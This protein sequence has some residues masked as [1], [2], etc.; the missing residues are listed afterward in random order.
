[1]GVE[2]DSKI[3]RMNKTSGAEKANATPTTKKDQER[4]RRIADEFLL[5]RLGLSDDFYW[6][7]E[8]ACM[9]IPKN[10]IIEERGFGE[11]MASLVQ[12][13]CK[14][15][16]LY[17]CVHYFLQAKSFELPD[18]GELE[19]VISTHDKAVGMI[20]RY[21]NEIITM[22]GARSIPPPPWV[23]E[24]V[25]STQDTTGFGEAIDSMPP[26]HK[27]V[28]FLRQLLRWCSKVM[29]AWES[30][31]PAPLT[32]GALP[33]SLYA[34]MIYF[35]PT[36]ET[37]SRKYTKR[38]EGAQIAVERLLNSVEPDTKPLGPKQPLPKIKSDSKRSGP[39][40][41]IGDASKISGLPH[42]ATL[43][44]NITNFDLRSPKV[45]AQLRV[46]L[47]ALHHLEQY[48]QARGVVHT[49]TGP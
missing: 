24:V 22:A 3:G 38:K 42:P 7:W 31:H 32:N 35:D 41:R 37:Y 11:A 29:K 9:E 34:D 14:K 4:S 17:S 20:G 1:M 21:G 10:Q 47:I 44:K 46:R 25:T 26:E 23:G 19:S 48:V 27:A 40:G 13:G 30:P 2:I 33:L 18:K 28:V 49:F 8:A 36:L 16:V 43:R 45:F 6:D 12:R 39:K 15:E 5:L